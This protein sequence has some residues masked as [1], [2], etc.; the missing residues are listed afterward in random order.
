M[1][2]LKARLWQRSGAC[3]GTSVTLFVG[4]MIAEAGRVVRKCEH[5][6]KVAKYK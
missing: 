5:E 6:E 4:V 2:L 1:L 3:T